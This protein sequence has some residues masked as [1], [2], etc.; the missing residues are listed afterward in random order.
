MLT[1][2]LKKF[3]Y[4]IKYTFKDSE[5]LVLALTHKSCSVESNKKKHNGRMEFLGDSIISAV[6]A[7]TL[8]LRYPTECEG[9]LSQLKSYLVSS[10]NLSSWSRKINLGD[11]IFLGKNEN[12]KKIRQKENLLCDMFESVTGAIYLDGG[13][14]SAKKFILNFLN[15]KREIITIDHRSQLQEIVQCGYKKLPVYKI[16]REFGPKHARRFVAAVY[17]KN[18]LFGKGVGSSKKEAHKLAA[19]QAIENV[20]HPKNCQSLSI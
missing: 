2:S 19:K 14:E 12:S 20:R 9:K 11:Y 3:Q 16:I 7:E 13:F 1:K 4:L 15:D 6:V 10:C 5:V 17:I 18:E 8:Y